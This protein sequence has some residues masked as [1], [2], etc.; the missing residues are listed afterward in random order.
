MG[1]EEKAFCHLKLRCDS[2]YRMAE[3]ISKVVFSEFHR[4]LLFL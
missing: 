1:C 2:N 3:S 4:E